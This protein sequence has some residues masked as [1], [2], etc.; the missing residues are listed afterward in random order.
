VLAVL[1]YCFTTLTGD[2]A[3]LFGVHPGE[4]ALAIASASTA[5]AVSATLVAAAST[6]A[7]RFQ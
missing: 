5:S 1:A 7:I 4:S 6:A 2:F 3:L